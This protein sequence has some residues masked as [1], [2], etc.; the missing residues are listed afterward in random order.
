MNTYF[1]QLH[2]PSDAVFADILEDSEEYWTKI[3]FFNEQ[4]YYPYGLFRNGLTIDFAPLTILYG[5]NGSGKSTV[6]NIIA[7]KMKIGRRTMINRSPFFSFFAENC[8]LGVH[9][10]F[11]ED[12]K[13]CDIITSDD[14]F[15]HCFKV[16]EMNGGITKEQKSVINDAFSRKAAISLGTYKVQ[17]LSS[18]DDFDR[19]RD[20]YEKTKLLRKSSSAYVKHFANHMSKP[21]SNGETAL[22]FFTTKIT[23]EGVFLLDEP[24]NSLSPVFQLKLMEFLEC[25]ARLGI[26]FIIA[27]HSPLL[28]GMENARILNLDEEG[29]PER[30][31]E[32]LENIQ[33]FNQFFKMKNGDR[34]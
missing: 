19:W 26:Q 5:N 13:R 6:L 3:N 1:T 22:E 7:E 10:D 17:P 8:Q 4:E 33:I 20:E 24:E 29:A 12:G 18:L 11:D 31:W 30:K 25:S 27:T 14:V 9:S 32:E 15:N 28:L 16:R 23:G 21:N 2:I 34:R